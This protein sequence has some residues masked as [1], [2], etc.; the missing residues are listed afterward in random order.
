[1]GRCGV[2]VPEQNQG[3]AEDLLLQQHQ[4]DPGSHCVQAKRHVGLAERQSAAAARGKAR[5]EVVGHC[6]YHARVLRE[7]AEA[8]VLLL[9]E[10]QQSIEPVGERKAEYTNKE[11]IRKCKI[12]R[13]ISH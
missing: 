5:Q 13:E 11:K 2:G 7:A 3:P 4:T 6:K 1:M 9:G 10:T 12:K 8:Q